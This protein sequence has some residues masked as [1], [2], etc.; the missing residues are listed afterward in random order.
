MLLNSVHLEDRD[1]ID[2][3]VINALGRQTLALAILEI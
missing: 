1:K 2:Q 3:L